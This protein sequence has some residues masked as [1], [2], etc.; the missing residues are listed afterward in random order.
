MLAG[1][2]VA[3][4][5]RILATGVPPAA[6]G[7]DGVGYREVVAVLQGRLPAGGL[8]E[9]IVI[10]TRQYAKRQETWFRHQLRSPSSVLSHPSDDVWV[11]DATPSSDSL[12]AMIHERW[13]HASS[14]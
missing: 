11:L 13:Q 3:E 4:V 2:L 7:L 6:P 10:A 14:D 9:A 1:G 12:A 5:E 8:R